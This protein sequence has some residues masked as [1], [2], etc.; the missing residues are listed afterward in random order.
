MRTQRLLHLNRETFYRCQMAEIRLVFCI[1]NVGQ[2]E[3]ITSGFERKGSVLSQYD[4][5][6]T[7]ELSSKIERIHNEN[8]SSGESEKTMLSCRSGLSTT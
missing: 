8:L 5:A 1:P 7:A 2:K 4:C 3:E 6:F